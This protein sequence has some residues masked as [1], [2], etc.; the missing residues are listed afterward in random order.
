[1]EPPSY[2][3]VTKPPAYSSAP[4][5]YI[6]SD[7]DGDHYYDDDGDGDHDDDHENAESSVQQSW[8]PPDGRRPPPEP[9]RP[10]DRL[11]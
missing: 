8:R 11:V 6:G 2:V 9:F 5:S 4:V 1:M 10:G 3:A 7:D